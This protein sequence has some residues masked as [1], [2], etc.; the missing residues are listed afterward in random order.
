MIIQRSS[1]IKEAGVFNFIHKKIIQISM[2]KRVTA[3]NLE[4]RAGMVEAGTRGCC[5][6]HFGDGFL[7]QSRKVRVNP[8]SY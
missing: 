5:E 4:Q 2:T 3:S 6:A 1:L 8:L 7:K